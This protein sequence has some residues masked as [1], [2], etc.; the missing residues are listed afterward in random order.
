MPTEE[1]CIQAA[2]EVLANGWLAQAQM[3]AREQAEG[4]WHPGSRFTVD[5]LEDRIRRKRGLPPI[6]DAKSA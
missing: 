1:E 3:T 6:H 2:G 5:E 4:A